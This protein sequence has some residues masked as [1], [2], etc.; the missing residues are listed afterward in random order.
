MKEDNVLDGSVLA[1]Y[2]K[3]DVYEVGVN[4]NR[5]VFAIEEN[6]NLGKDTLEQTNQAKDHFQDVFR[7]NIASVSQKD[8]DHNE[9]IKVVENFHM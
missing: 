8:K 5:I 9:S 3:D 2:V 4:S 7:S 1:H 6:K